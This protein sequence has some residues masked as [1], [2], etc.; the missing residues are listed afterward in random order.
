MCSNDFAE[1][2]TAIVAQDAVGARKLSLGR[3]ASIPSILQSAGGNLS[4]TNSIKMR[5]NT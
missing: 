5:E 1:T 3:T 2:P 4:V